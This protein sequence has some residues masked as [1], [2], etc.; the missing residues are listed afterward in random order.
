MKP[1]GSGRLAKSLSTSPNRSSQA[2]M[3]PGSVPWG[4]MLFAYCEPVSGLCCFRNS[5]GDL[6]WA[7]VQGAASGLDSMCHRLVER[8]LP[9][10]CDLGHS[11]RLSYPQ[12]CFLLLT[13]DSKINSCCLQTSEVKSGRAFLRL[14]VGELWDWM[15][16][17]LLHVPCILLN[18]SGSNS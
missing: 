6:S 16:P 10:L 9:A 12:D 18:S 14:P 3:K 5:E 8:G 15:V 17:S 1:L 4:T 7:L 2:G 11:H 13:L